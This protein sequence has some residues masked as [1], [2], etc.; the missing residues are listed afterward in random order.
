MKVR[1]DEGAFLSQIQEEETTSGSGTSGGSKFMT[2]L[3]SNESTPYLSCYNS[4]SKKRKLG[5][6]SFEPELAD[7]SAR[8]R[9]R[10][11]DSLSKFSDE[12]DILQ[13]EMSKLSLT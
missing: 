7:F 2:A 5:E 8:K 1:L 13:G 12:I 6:A 4:K 10:D 3:E 11:N 9:F